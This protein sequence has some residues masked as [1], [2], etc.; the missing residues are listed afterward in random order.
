MTVPEPGRGVY[1]YHCTL[2]VTLH[3]IIK[4]INLCACGNINIIAGASGS[5][6]RGEAS[7]ENEEEHDINT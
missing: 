7:T 2:R 4:I 3:H 1:V 5:G 6:E